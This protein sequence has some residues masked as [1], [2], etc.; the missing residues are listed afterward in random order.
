MK[1]C[2]NLLSGLPITVM[3][4]VGCGIGF[5]VLCGIITGVVCYK[6]IISKLVHIIKKDEE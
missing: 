3:I 1:F 2:V 4:S 6:V 5:I